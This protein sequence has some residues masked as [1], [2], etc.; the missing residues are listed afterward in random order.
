MKLKIVTAAKDMFMRFGIKSVSMDD[1]AR[2][3]GISKKTLYLHLENKAELIALILNDKFEEEKTAMAGF[4]K[5][6]KNA[7][8]EILSIA[9]FIV[10]T[11]REMP[12]T[13]IY[14]LQKYYPEKWKVF[15]KIYKKHIYDVVW[16]NLKWGM[17]QG[18]YRADLNAD[19][20]TKFYVGKTLIIADEE[21]FPV[22]TYD[23]DVV[24]AE[25]M[26][27][28]IRGIASPK[29]LTLLEMLSLKF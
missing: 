24:F 11:L 13:I 4:R 23:C 25:H 19:I 14:D 20:I 3:M 10:A 29:G 6:S 26:K 27:Y 8:E 21:L 2:K 16:N 12:P 7:L 15:D 5:N 9:D 18:L 28:H 17:K 22:G 1:I